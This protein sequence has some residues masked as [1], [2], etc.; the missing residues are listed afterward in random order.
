[1]K[2]KRFLN[3]GLQEE[4]APIRARRK[5]LEADIPSV[6]KILQ[7]GSL[8]AQEKAHETVMRVRRALGV[9]Y[10]ENRKLIE[11][12]SKAFKK[13]LE[14][15]KKMEAFIIVLPVPLKIN[16]SVWGAFLLLWKRTEPTSRLLSF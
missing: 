10:F 4:L 2:V 13:K 11:K 5:E 6:Y 3:A 1:M 15:E 12:Q 14:D 9:N 7:E 16:T 8:K